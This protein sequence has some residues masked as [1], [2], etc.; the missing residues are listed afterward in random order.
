[1]MHRQKNP[2]LGLKEHIIKGHKLV[3]EQEQSRGLAKVMKTTLDITESKKNKNKI[4]KG[5]EGQTF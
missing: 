5:L 3:P 4:K 2:K 1:M